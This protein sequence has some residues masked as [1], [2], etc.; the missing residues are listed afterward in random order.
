[1]CPTENQ[2]L[3]QDELW[4]L[5]ETP[6]SLGRVDL[7]SFVYEEVLSFEDAG[8]ATDLEIQGD[9]AVV[10]LENRVVNVRPNRGRHRA[11]R[12]SRSRAA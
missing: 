2:V 1:M 6:P 3:A 12:R 5:N 10:V 4:V 9:A 7:T 8:F 11:S